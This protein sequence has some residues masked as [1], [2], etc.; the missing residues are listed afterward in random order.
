MMAVINT[1]DVITKCDAGMKAAEEVRGKFVSRQ[2]ALKKQEEAI[3]RLKV[4]PALSD[5]KSGKREALESLVR[6]FV[7]DNQALRKNVGEEE[8]ARFKPVVD[9]INKILAEYAKEHG[10]VSVQDKNGF[11]YI[12]PAID[13]TEAIIKKVDEAK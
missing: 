9:K 12:A 6:Q 10:L 3:E 7:A 2:E 1:R 13:I 5:P 11:A 4:E 8:A